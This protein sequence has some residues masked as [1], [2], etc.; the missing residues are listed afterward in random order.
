M[1]Y[2]ISPYTHDSI[3]VMD[4]RYRMA[5]KACSV[6]VDRKIVIYSPIVHW[7]LIA[8]AREL[9]RGH[10][11]WM[12]HDHEMIS[13]STAVILLKLKGWEDSDGVKRDVEEAEKLGKPIIYAELPE[14]L[15]IDL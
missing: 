3:H 9:P 8:E 5:C 15:T 6:L 1:I 11:F 14:L 10:E 7:H 2:L 12:F 4:Y 13:L